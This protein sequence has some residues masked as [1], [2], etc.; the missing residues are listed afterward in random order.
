MFSCPIRALLAH[1]LVVPIIGFFALTGFVERLH[2]WKEGGVQ[3][4]S[5][6][7]HNTKST[8]CMSLALTVMSL[9]SY[10]IS[11]HTLPQALTVGLN[12]GLGQ[13]INLTSKTKLPFFSVTRRSRSDGSH[14]LTE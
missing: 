7:E 8:L 6:A 9:I 1:A 13:I 12:G 14:S 5:I 10:A 2:T 4:M 11:Y 3:F